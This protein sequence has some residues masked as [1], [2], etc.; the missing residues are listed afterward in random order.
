MPTTPGANPA[1]VTVA[2]VEPNNTVRPAM[3]F[4]VPVIVPGATAGVVAPK[5]I[6]YAVMLSPGAA[7]RNGTPEIS[8]GL[9]TKLPSGNVATRYW[10]PPL[11]KLDGASTP[12]ATGASCTIN[13]ALAHAALVTTRGTAPAAVSAGACTLI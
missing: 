13:G 7:G 8:P 9:P 5:P 12:G 6:P 11:L 4:A 1:Y 3:L 10:V 2:G